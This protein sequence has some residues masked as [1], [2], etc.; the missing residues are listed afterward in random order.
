MMSRKYWNK[1]LI[2]LLV[3]GDLI[4]FILALQLTTPNVTRALHNPWILMFAAG[5]VFSLVLSGRYT[6]DGTVSRV[7]EA[8]QVGR[9]ILV[10]TIGIILVGIVFEA[11]LPMGPRGWAKLAFVFGALIVPYRWLFRSV[12]KYLFRFNLG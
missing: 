3:L 2:G 7:D 9:T 4:G 5:I 10:L 1:L 8:V 11:A 6:P 12:Q